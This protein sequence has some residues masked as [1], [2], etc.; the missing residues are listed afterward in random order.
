MEKRHGTGVKTLYFIYM[1]VAQV[2]AII[3][4]KLLKILTVYH[5]KLY[6]HHHKFLLTKQGNLIL[7]ISLLIYIF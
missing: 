3:L 4:T 5:R 1:E 6:W 2:W 7:F